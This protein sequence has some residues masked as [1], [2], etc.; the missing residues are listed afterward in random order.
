M[1]TS[2][3][4][5]AQEE[6]KAAKENG[7][8]APHSSAANTPPV[9]ER[10]KQRDATRIAPWRWK[11]GQSGNPRGGAVR[12]D[13]AAEIARA[14]FENNA[15]VLYKAFSKAL[16]RGNAYAYKELADRAYGKMKESIQHEVRPYAEQTDEEIRERIKQLEKEL[17]ISRASPEV[18]PPESDPKPN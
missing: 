16:R 5:E 17:G 4:I 3:T 12:H 10:L 2:E 13:L 9:R 11:P 14:V 8:V 7:G 6:R 18:L 15:E 1:K